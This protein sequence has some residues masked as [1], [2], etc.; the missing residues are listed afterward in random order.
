MRLGAKDWREGEARLG[1]GAFDAPLNLSRKGDVV[2]A[3]ANLFAMLH[4]LD[5][6]KPK[7]IAVAAIPMQGLGEAINDRLRRAAAPRE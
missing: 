3:A 6:A 5:A 7:V 2:E 4:Q 1:F